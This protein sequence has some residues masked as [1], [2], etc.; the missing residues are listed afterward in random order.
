M[1]RPI[2]SNTAEAAVRAY[3]GLTQ[4]ELGRYLGVSERQVGHLEAGRRQATAATNRRLERLFGLLPPPDGTGPPAPLFGPLAIP[5]ESI[6]G[7]GLPDFGPLAPRPLL[8]RQRRVSFQVAQLRWALHRQHKYLA[9]QHRRQ[10]G[11]A[12]LQAALPTESL[13]PAERA[14]L[15]RW[16]TVLAADVAA[17]VPRP[18]AVAQRALIVVQLLSL[19]AELAMLAQ[20]LAQKPPPLPR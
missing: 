9:R 17:A 16:L 10:W 12:R 19:T 15:N 7:V 13:D 14:H 8:A 4:A 6:P 18:L 20:L 5:E 3:F 11:L 1:S 2:P